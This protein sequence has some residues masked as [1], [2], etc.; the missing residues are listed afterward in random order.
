MIAFYLKYLPGNIYD[1]NLASTV[2][3]FGAIILSGFMYKKMGLKLA[4]TTLLAISV[5]GG[6]MILFVGIDSTF[7]MPF[8]VLIAKF[9]ISG[10]FNLC[11]CST[12][13]VFPTLFCGT[14]IGICNFFGRIITIFAPIVAEKPWPLPMV[15]FTGFAAIGMIVI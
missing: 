13:Y 14:A 1:N 8:F 5:V 3:E 2:S 10:G 15:L 12:V 6:C 4:F 7:W 11:Y 9:G